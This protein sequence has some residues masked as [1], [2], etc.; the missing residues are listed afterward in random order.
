LKNGGIPLCP[1]PLDPLVTFDVDNGGTS[2][3]RLREEG[4]PLRTLRRSTRSESRLKRP[5]GGVRYRREISDDDERDEDYVPESS[6]DEEEME[7]ND[8]VVEQ[9][10][11]KRKRELSKFIIERIDGKPKRNYRHRPEKEMAMVQ[12]SAPWEE[13]E[14]EEPEETF[15][16][17]LLEAEVEAAEV[18]HEEIPRDILGQL[19]GYAEL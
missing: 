15:E 7:H 2:D 11:A 14:I 8:L 12:Q 18:E 17:D 19:K 16:E 10:K 4:N 5:L 9:P 13:E 3:L 1:Q 6:E